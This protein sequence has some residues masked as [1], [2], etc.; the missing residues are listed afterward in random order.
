VDNVKVTGVLLTVN[1]VSNTASVTSASDED[2]HTIVKLDV[3]NDLAGGQVNLDGVEDVNAGVGVAD[4][5]AIVGDNNGHV[6]HC[7][8]Q[9]SDQGLEFNKNNNKREVD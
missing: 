4:G 8:H 5:A 6:L 9:T 1:N 2:L 7:K 3:V